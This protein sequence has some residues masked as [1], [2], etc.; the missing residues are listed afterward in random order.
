MKRLILMGAAL[1]ML[2]SLTFSE[3]TTIG[4]GLGFK[5]DLEV[6]VTTEGDT[7]T[8]IRV[9]EHMD[10]DKYADGA[11]AVLIPEMLENQTTDIDSFAGAT[12]T[13]LGL[14]EAVT[15]A[16]NKQNFN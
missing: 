16:L 3:T 7:I 6:V 4:K 14:K 11:F 1:L 5:G 15:D 9:V 13:S 12:G 10:T 2:S 8:D